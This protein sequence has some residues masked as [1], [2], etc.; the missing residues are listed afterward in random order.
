LI[1][2]HGVVV[3]KK[4][5]SHFSQCV[6]PML[7]FVNLPIASPNNEQHNLKNK[8]LENDRLEG[9]LHFSCSKHCLYK[10]LQCCRL[11]WF[12]CIHLMHYICN[13]HA[14]GP[15]LCQW[16]LW[17]H[18]HLNKQTLRSIMDIVQGCPNQQNKWLLHI[19]ELNFVSSRL[20]IWTHPP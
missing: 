8:D 13:G 11:Q 1:V 16:N 20:P 17:I 10:F 6:S 15:Q 3:W 9:E 18:H 7:F 4:Q 5:L 14:F 12:H 2:V 19:C